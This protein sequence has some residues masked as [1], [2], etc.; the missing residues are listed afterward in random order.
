MLVT[1][2]QAYITVTD[3]YHWYRL[4]SLVNIGL[5]HWYRLISLAQAY[6]TDTGLYHWY[7]LI[8]LAQAYITGTGLYHWYRLISLIQA[9]ITDTGLYH[10]YGIG[11]KCRIISLIQ[12]CITGGTLSK[13]VLARLQTLQINRWADVTWSSDLQLC[14]I[15]GFN[16]K[17]WIRLHAVTAR[18]ARSLQMHTHTHTVI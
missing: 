2:A 15:N 7:R 9:Y 14:C 16:T 18:R 1:L 4:I 8:S 12:A 11:L 3:L 10:W 17:P 6:I 13:S 5:Y